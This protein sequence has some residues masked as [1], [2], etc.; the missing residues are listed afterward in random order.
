[1]RIYTLSDNEDFEKL[2]W[3]IS[4]FKYLY[5]LQQLQT[6]TIESLNR[7]AADPILLFFESHRFLCHLI[8]FQSHF[9]YEYESYYQKILNFFHLHSLLLFK[10]KI[11]Q[12][13]NYKNKLVY[14]EVIFRSG[15]FYYFK[16]Y[17]FRREI[18]DDLGKN[19]GLV[20]QQQFEFSI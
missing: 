14:R 6:D 5:L 11:T 8:Y 13:R 19:A 7:I 3:S 16:K 9:I 2:N 18:M 10:K 20:R 1:M 4:R 15:D 17:R 12:Y